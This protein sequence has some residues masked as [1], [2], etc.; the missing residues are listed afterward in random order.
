MTGDFSS[1]ARLDAALGC[2]IWWVAALP[3]AEGLELDEVLPTQ[4][5]LRFYHPS[6]SLLIFTKLKIKS[7]K[8]RNLRTLGT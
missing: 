3:T 7:F 8:F 5:I 4:A 2:L 1:Q 6:V